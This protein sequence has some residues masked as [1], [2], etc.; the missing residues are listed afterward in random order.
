M[1]QEV[2]MAKTVEQM[3]ETMVAP[4]RDHCPEPVRAAM[5]CSHGGSMASALTAAVTRFGGLTKTSDLPNPVLVAVGEHGVYAFSFKPRG[6]KMKV[7]KEVRRWN[8]A[9]VA[10]A[11]G[12]GT[13][14]KSFSLCAPEG[15]YDFEATTM[16][17]DDQNALLDTFIDAVGR[18]SA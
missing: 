4:T 2:E 15:H 11:G 18:V 5:V 13:R 16:N 10:I 8:R 7:K 14:I 12:D 1:G 17:R 9:D 6:F 3:M